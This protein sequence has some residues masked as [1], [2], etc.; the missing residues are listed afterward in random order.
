MIYLLLGILIVAHLCEV[1]FGSCT[2]VYNAEIGYE[3]NCE[4]IEKLMQ[5]QYFTELLPILIF[6]IGL[7]LLI[8]N[9]ISSFK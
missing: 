8:C 3:S 5:K 1:V 4:Q 9:I 6:A 7:P 2:G